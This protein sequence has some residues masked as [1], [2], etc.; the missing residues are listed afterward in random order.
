MV[1]HKNIERL[2]FGIIEVPTVA[3]LET[4][5]NERFFDIL[6]PSVNRKAEAYAYTTRV[7]GKYNRDFKITVFLAF[8]FVKGEQQYWFGLSDKEKI[9]N[10][11]SQSKKRAALEQLKTR[12]YQE[13]HERR[14]DSE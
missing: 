8:P 9:P 11:W 7:T 4:Y 1:T 6:D 3:H 12:F 2:A 13:V 14:F 10:S 5:S